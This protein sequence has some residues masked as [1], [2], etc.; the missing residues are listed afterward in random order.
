M[1]TGE[2]EGKGESQARREGETHFRAS[3][4][5]ETT[6]LTNGGIFMPFLVVG[7]EEMKSGTCATQRSQRPWPFVPSC[8]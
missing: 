4:R 7:M 6:G 3:G 2:K 5:Q 8:I 1:K